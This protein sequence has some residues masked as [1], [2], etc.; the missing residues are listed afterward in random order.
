MKP[1]ELN[2]LSKEYVIEH[3]TYFDGEEICWCDYLIGNCEGVLF[4]GLLYEIYDNDILAYYSYYENGKKHGL[5]VDFYLSG[6]PKSYGVFNKG[7]LVGKSYEWYENGLIKRI[8]NYYKND[9]H[10]KYIE[11]DENG[12]TINQGEA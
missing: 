4:T 2:I 7:N 5:S 12:N 8:R 9:C 1:N 11:Y 6:K 3:G 10:Y